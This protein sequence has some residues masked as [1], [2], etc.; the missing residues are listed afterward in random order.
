MR[1]FTAMA[2]L[3]ALVSCDG[4]PTP[5]AQSCEGC[6]NGETCLKGT[7]V[8]ACGSGGAKCA[9]CFSAKLTC[10]QTT[11][12]CEG[13]GLGSC[14]GSCAGCC[15]GDACLPGT[16]DFKCGSGG[17]A[18]GDCRAQGLFC[19][20]SGVCGAGNAGAGGG[21]GGG[22][23]TGSG[24]GAGGGSSD[25]TVTLRYEYQTCPAGC[26]DCTK[27]F[28]STFKVMSESTFATLFRPAYGACVVSTQVGGY[29]IDCSP[30][31]TPVTISCGMSKYAS[32]YNCT[33]PMYASSTSCYW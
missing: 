4:G 9:D 1:T 18:C 16:S 2:A 22:G 23:G 10:S 29:V 15:N 32:K 19:S 3:F 8:S 28:C 7:N 30:N 20:A 13:T 5:C 26:T 21:G 17:Q 24:S 11:R 27:R 6:C 14:G 12:Q 25:V 31:C 33:T